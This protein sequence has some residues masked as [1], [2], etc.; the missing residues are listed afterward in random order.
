MCIFEE[1]CR[2]KPK[3]IYATSSRQSTTGSLFL[4]KALE[5]MQAYKDRKTIWLECNG[6]WLNRIAGY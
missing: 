1:N 5:I 3:G 2:H 4:G 6:T